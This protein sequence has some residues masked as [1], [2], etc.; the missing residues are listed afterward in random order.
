MVSAKEVQ[1]L[2]KRIEYINVQ[3]TKAE[4]R[5]EILKKQLEDELA[6]YK[7]KFGVSLKGKS[8]EETKKNIQAELDSVVEVVE[9]EYRLKEKVVG[10]IERGDYDTAYRLLG[11]DRGTN[12]DTEAEEPEEGAK[13]GVKLPEPGK[14]VSEPEYSAPS[15]GVGLSKDHFAGIA[16]EVGVSE[17]PFAK[18]VA[19]GE[20]NEEPEIEEGEE[21]EIEEE[22]NDGTAVVM[23]TS[24]T[25]P[26]S[27]RVS[28]T[29]SGSSVSSAVADMVVEGDTGALPDL[30][31]TDFGFGDLLKGTKF[32]L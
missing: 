12:S 28:K 24:K 30:D 21:E 15:R 18:L 9:A 32:G 7:S 17:D 1:A 22:I 14:V 6:S 25:V 19:E 27:K 23:K 31:D 5:I 29:I 2:N 16:G 8:F 11:I 4:T 20:V 13:L 26:E 3:R 10:A